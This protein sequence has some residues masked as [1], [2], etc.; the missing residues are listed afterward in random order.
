MVNR[1]RLIVGHRLM[2]AGMVLYGLMVA[3]SLRAITEG[4]SQTLESAFLAIAGTVYAISA[5]GVTLSVFAQGLSS[6]RSIAVTALSVALVL[7]PA[8]GFLVLALHFAFAI[9][10]LKRAGVAVKWLWA[11]P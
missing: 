4:T 3:L 7:V 6:V 9:R 11:R 1:S 2:A 10:A 8:I 5:A